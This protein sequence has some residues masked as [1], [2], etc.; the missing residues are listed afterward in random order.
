VKQIVV[1][2]PDEL[3]ELAGGNESQ[4]V[5]LM[6]QA[7]VAEFVRRGVISS[8]KASELLGVDRWSIPDILGKFEVP[9]CDFCPEEDLKPF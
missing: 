9:A 2:L 4:A 3:F 1:N 8:G 7:V 5:K 6:T